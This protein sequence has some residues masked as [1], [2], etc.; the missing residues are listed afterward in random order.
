MYG[1]RKDTRPQRWLQAR[2]VL[3]Q[4]PHRARGRSPRAPH[5][6]ASRWRQ[7]RLERRGGTLRLHRT[8]PARPCARLPSH[9][10]RGR[11][12]APRMH[13][14]SRANTG[15]KAKRRKKE[16]KNHTRKLYSLRQRKS[17]THERMEQQKRTREQKHLETKERTLRDLPRRERGQ[18]EPGGSRAAAGPPVAAEGWGVA[19]CA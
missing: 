14:A 17:Y 15:L 5:L 1:K 8:A 7:T 13:S 12:P 19:G 3:R 2:R 9:S 16:E 4:R 10:T 11:V 18:N 6:E